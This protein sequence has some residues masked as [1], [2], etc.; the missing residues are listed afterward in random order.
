MLLSDKCPVNAQWYEEHSISN[1]LKV[2]RLRM[3]IEL[4]L[5]PVV[6]GA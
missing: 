6:I 4:A 1:N 2:T 5:L 3:V